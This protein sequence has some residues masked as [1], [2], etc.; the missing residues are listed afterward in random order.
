MECV[1]GAQPIDVWYGGSD[2]TSGMTGKH[3][4]EYSYGNVL[5]CQPVSSE[6]EQKSQTMLKSVKVVG[7]P[8]C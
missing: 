8:R 1:T 5:E 7:G 3:L 4:H 6:L 2:V